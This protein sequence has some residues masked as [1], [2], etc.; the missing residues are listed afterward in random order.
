MV[1]VFSFCLYGPPNQSYYPMPTLQ[2]IHLIRKYFPDWKVYLYTAPDVDPEFLEQVAM[3]SNVVIRPTEKLG[4]VNMFYRFFAIDEPDVEIMMV[5][6]LDSRVHW[7]DRWAINQ[8][9]NNIQYDSH[10]I[11]DNIEHTSKM[12]GGLW[13]MRKIDGLII[14]YLYKLYKESPSDRGY[15]ADQ[16]FLTDYVYPYLWKNALVH[17]SNGRVIAEEKAVQFP[18]EYVNEV[19]CGRYEIS[20]SFI[21]HPQPPFSAEKPERRFRFINQKLIIKT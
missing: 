1:N 6:D 2:N 10:I 9:L 20:E 15:G 16:S 19:Y 21:D 12:M 8:F 4:A 7:K 17:Y 18:F 11:R 3:Y 14:E 5:R 13:G